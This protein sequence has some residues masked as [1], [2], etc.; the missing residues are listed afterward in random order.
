M[1]GVSIEQRYTDEHRCPVC[2][3]CPTDPQGEGVRCHGFISSDGAHAHCSREEHAGHLPVAGGSGTYAHLVT[4]DACPCGQE[5]DPNTA[6]HGLIAALPRPTNVSTTEY[7]IKA[8]DG[9]L[10]A[11]HM[12]IDKSDGSKRVWW[13]RPNG[14]KGL[15]T[16]VT[17]LP[18]YGIDTLEQGDVI[19][20][21]GE[22]AC[23]ALRDLD[24]NAVGT[25]T[26]ASTI[27][28]EMMLRPLLGRRVFLWPDNDKQ[29]KSHMRRIAAILRELGHVSAYTLKWT[30]APEAGDAFDFFASGKSVEELETMKEAAMPQSEVSKTV[31]ETLLEEADAAIDECADNN[32]II[33]AVEYLREHVGQHLRVY[34]FAKVAGLVQPIEEPQREIWIGTLASVFNVARGTVRDAVG[35]LGGHTAILENSLGIVT[36][37][38]WETEVHGTEVATEIYEQIKNYCILPDYAARAISLW[39]IYTYV[40]DLFDHSPMLA[41]TS[42]AKRCGKTRLLGLVSMFVNRALPFSNASPAAIF[43][44]IDQAKPT[45]IADE[46]ERYI[47]DDSNELT[48]ILNASHSK[49][50]AWIIRTAGDEH[51]AKRFST[52]SAKAFALIGKLTDTLMDRSIEIP[53]KRRTKNETIQ[54]LRKT[55]QRQIEALGIPRKLI[56]W[57]ADNRDA[58]ISAEVH[59]EAPAALHDR[60]A[61]NWLPLL[62]IADVIGGPWPAWAREAALALT[63]GEESVEVGPNVE[64]LRDVY[65]LFGQAENLSTHVILTTLTSRTG[66]YVSWVHG[67]PLS[68]KQ[69]A[70]ALGAFNIYSRN[71]RAEETGGTVKKGYER[72]DFEDAV[73]RYVPSSTDS[74]A[75]P[76]QPASTLRET[77]RSAP[78]TKE[79]LAGIKTNSLSSKN[80]ACSG[81]AGEKALSEAPATKT[82][83]T[84]VVSTAARR[85]PVPAVESKPKRQPVS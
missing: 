30:D 74:P 42:P 68:D 85:Q 21:E 22:K 6:Q 14:E 75:T 36:A 9:T 37:E 18:L 80:A 29:G 19:L 55:Q 28:D 83:R 59:M 25:V 27:P 57:S 77:V 67:K 41:L 34:F 66:K 10:V 24:I 48:G 82:T 20:T 16:K 79:S 3:G 72:S 70:K 71:I 62:S 58:L 65:D 73:A 12:R 53:L 81:A 11:V 31:Q 33:G 69:L 23:D 52:W 17:S 60:A 51:I 61:D 7:E 15:I 40:I 5:H 1:P 38:P 63:T 76:L 2:G 54:P 84:P 35:P 26:G 44:I 50:M 13:Q 8:A 4:S 64:V 47:R 32:N 46:V 56:R 39:C 43:R 49:A 78:A 45:L